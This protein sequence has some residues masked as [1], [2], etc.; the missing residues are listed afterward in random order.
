MITIG[1]TVPE[2]EAVRIFQFEPG[3]HYEIKKLVTL[4]KNNSS[5]LLALCSDGKIYTT[6]RDRVWWQFGSHMWPEL[7]ALAQLGVIT[8]AMVRKHIQEE[9]A[10][11]K[12]RARSLKASELTRLASACGIKLTPVQLRKLKQP[13]PV[14]PVDPELLQD[15]LQQLTRDLKESH[16]GEL[17]QKHHGDNPSTCSYCRSIKW[18]TKLLKDCGVHI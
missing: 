3:K 10:F 17:L 16:E 14:L 2:I 9:K 8:R 12:R 13:Q 6:G 18:A 15:C 5:R 1:S 4:S 7:H 11:T